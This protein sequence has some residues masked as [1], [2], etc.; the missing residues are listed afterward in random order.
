MSSRSDKSKCHL[1]RGDAVAGD[2]QRKE[3][4][5]RRPRHTPRAAS[6]AARRSSRSGSR[7]AAPESRRRTADTPDWTGWA[8]GLRR[9]RRWTSRARPTRMRVISELVIDGRQKHR[10]EDEPQDV[11]GPSGQWLQQ[12]ARNGD[13]APVNSH[14]PGSSDGP[15]H[16]AVS[17]LRSTYRARA[18]NP[19][20][21]RQEQQGVSVS[22]CRRVCAGAI[23]A[24]AP[25]TRLAVRQGE[26][27]LVNGG[28]R[29]RAWS[30]R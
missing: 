30:A 3:A 8:S 18:G 13:V 2:R 5:G 7:T 28:G 26:T 27:S 6:T 14:V 19:R 29:S 17:G 10:R 15:Q 4:P 12:A 23:S 11:V 16:A 24:L 25:G 9:S 22:S 20:T 1:R 21:C